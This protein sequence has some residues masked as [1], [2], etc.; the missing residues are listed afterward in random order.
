MITLRGGL[1]TLIDALVAAMPQVDLRCDADVS[2]LERVGG[3]WTVRC[4]G[5]TDLPADDVVLATPAF[6]AATFLRPLSTAA[7]DA[8]DAIPYAGV[9]TVLLGYRRADIPRALD[10]SG[11]LVP[12]RDRRMIV[13]CTWA[14]AKW[15]HL[16]EGAGASEAVVLRCAVGRHGDSRWEAMPDDA[17]VAAV[18]AELE[19]SM[20]VRAVPAGVRVRRWPRS[21]PQYIVG[22]AQRLATIDA[23]V[24]AL[25][26]LH[27]TGAGYRG[28]GIAGCIA[29]ADK[30][31]REV[32]AR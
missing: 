20:G 9:A 16:A 11:F 25:P 2:G 19:L 1:T 28:V 17:V 23:E 24:A 32:L 8:L 18:R 29:Q 4:A 14:T 27:L 22:H 26:G 21:M 3:R 5:G 15:Q 7:A 13:G 31:A 12:P 10:G 6:A 30:I